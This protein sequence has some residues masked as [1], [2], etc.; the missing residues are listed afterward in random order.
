MLQPFPVRICHAL[1]HAHLTHHRALPPPAIVLCAVTDQEEKVLTSNYQ[2]LKMA[3]ARFQESKI[4]LE[5]V[6]PESEG[7]TLLV[8]LTSSLYVPGKLADSRN[9]MVDIGTGYYVRKS[10]ADAITFFE[11]KVKLL[12]NNTDGLQR[13]INERR[14]NLHQ[15]ITVMNERIRREQAAGAAAGGADA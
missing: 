12:K 7:S 6:K 3:E 4:A 13:T 2:Q 10:V 14:A 1:S 8:P 9:V 15:I 5:A 11:K